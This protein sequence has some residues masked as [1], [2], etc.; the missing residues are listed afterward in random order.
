MKT[1]RFK[2]IE[3]KGNIWSMRDNGYI[4][5]STN[6][7]VKDGLNIMGKGT[8]AQAK[9]KFP[10]LPHQLG[11]LI[12]E[13][14]N[15]LYFFPEYRLITFPVKQHWAQNANMHFIRR[16]AQELK[17]LQQHMHYRDDYSHIYLP[18]VGCGSGKLEWEDVKPVL[19]EY[20]TNEYFII[21][22]KE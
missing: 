20:L 11:K 10:D 22:D 9:M 17:K 21:I 8:A 4:V 6:G 16:S 19:E 13:K 14:G 18:K 2:L 12:L 1:E 7:I 15:H 5:V 3:I